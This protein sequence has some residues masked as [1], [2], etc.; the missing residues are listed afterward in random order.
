MMGLCRGQSIDI[1][2]LMW[3]ICAEQEVER[4]RR[5]RN[6]DNKKWCPCVL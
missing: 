3:V 6:L 5:T 2:A 1:L 4:G